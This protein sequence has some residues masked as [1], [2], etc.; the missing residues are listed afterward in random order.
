MANRGRPGDQPPQPGRGGKPEELTQPLE[1][2]PKHRLKAGELQLEQFKK[3]AN[4]PEFLKEVKMTKEEFERFVAGYEAMLKRQ[5]P[6]GEPAPAQP[7]TP[8][9]GPP[10]PRIN[11]NTG[12]EKVEGKA[13]DKAAKSGGPV[14]APPGFRDAQKQFTEDAGKAP[15]PKK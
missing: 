1:V 12:P 2:D 13:D 8:K 10:V 15:A 5:P 9:D 6:A 14:F 3:K 7:P 4:D 11:V